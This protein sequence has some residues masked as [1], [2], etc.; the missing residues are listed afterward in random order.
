MGEREII[1][2]ARKKRG[3]ET[4]EIFKRDPPQ[5]GQR[6]EVSIWPTDLKNS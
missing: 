4:E 3:E 1:S 5:S 2:L 6:G